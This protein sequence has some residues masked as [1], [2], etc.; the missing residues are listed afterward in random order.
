MDATKT[1]L[2]IL[3]EQDVP[4]ERLSET[5]NRVANN[6][7][8][9]QGQ[10]AALNPDNPTA[11]D[12]VTQAKAAIDVGQLERAHQLLREAT[13]AQL[14]AAQE[15][16]KLRE[17][18]Q[19]A[20]DAQ[21]LGAANA[22]AVDAGVALTEGKYR[23]AADLFGQAAGYVPPGH[24]DELGSYLSSQAGALYR[25]GDERGDNDA[26]CSAIEILR[27]VLERRE[28]VPL[29]WAMTQNKRGAALQVLG[30]RR[31]SAGMSRAARTRRA[32]IR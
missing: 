16:R 11:R 9:L 6:Y 22:T 32:A 7:K 4:L 28:R 17:Q 18:A 3:G 24:P 29:D 25:Q 14:A 31:R 12:L 21:M 27:L 20:E 23:Q 8:R 30:E 13:Q 10:A 19:A 2:R 1:L 15:A 26:L 5:L